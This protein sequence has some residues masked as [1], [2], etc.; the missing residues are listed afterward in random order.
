[1]SHDSFDPVGEVG[2]G[3]PMRRM[4]ITGQLPV[5]RNVR[6]TANLLVKKGWMSWQSVSRRGAHSVEGIAVQSHEL[7]H[8]HRRLAGEFG[9]ITSLSRYQTCLP[10]FA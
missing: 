7:L 4:R 6:C 1:M 5:G 8:G 9:E 3:E 10:N 2:W